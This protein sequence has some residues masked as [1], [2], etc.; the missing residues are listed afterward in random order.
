[1]KSTFA[2][3]LINLGR[4]IRIVVLNGFQVRLISFLG[5]V[6]HGFS[7]GLNHGVSACLASHLRQRPQIAFFNVFSHQIRMCAV[8]DC[9][10]AEAVRLLLLRSQLIGLQLTLT[11]G[12]F[13]P[14]VVDIQGI[15]ELRVKQSI[16][17]LLQNFLPLIEV[18]RMVW[19][20]A[21]KPLRSTLSSH[22][23][24]LL[25]TQVLR[26]LG[27]LRLLVLNSSKVGQT[28]IS[29]NQGGL[30]LKLVGNLKSLLRVVLRRSKR[31]LACPVKN[32]LLWSL[33]RK[34]KG[35]A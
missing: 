19:G 9:A 35:V 11:S 23:C 25:Q 8:L 31:K 1:M 26:L 17:V 13:I 33:L 28:L 3:E 2:S 21:S 27:N 4:C 34:A 6:I 20:D 22:L 12:I 29:A 16:R 30:C 14:L 15:A 18:F 24:L 5:A 7:L 10:K 32:R